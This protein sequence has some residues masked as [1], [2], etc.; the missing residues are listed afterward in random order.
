MTKTEFFAALNLVP[1]DDTSVVRWSTN[2][3]GPVTA[4][5]RLDAIG[6]DGSEV[7]E[8][9]VYETIGGETSYVTG[10]A[11]IDPSGEVRFPDDRDESMFE[12]FVETVRLMG[13][14]EGVEEVRA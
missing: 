7:Y 3:P 2:P 8:L 11:S 14:D 5:A 9:G 10:R 4:T 1:D 6:H 13:R 12:R